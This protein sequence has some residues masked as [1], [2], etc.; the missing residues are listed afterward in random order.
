[1]E[2]HTPQQDDLTFEIP[3]LIN[4]PPQ[5]FGGYSSDGSPLVAQLP[6]PIFTEDQTQMG[7]EESNEAKRRRIARVD[8]HEGVRLVHWTDTV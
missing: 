2:P 4:P 1:M 6:G 3:Q 5:I 8:K 7:V